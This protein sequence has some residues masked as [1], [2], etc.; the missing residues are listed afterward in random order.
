MGSAPGRVTAP[1]EN[2]PQQEFRKSLVAKS[3]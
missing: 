1:E 3:D 2:G